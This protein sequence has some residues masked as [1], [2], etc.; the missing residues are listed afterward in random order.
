[1]FSSPT[2]RWAGGTAAVCLGLVAVTYVG[3]V[4]PRRGEAADLTASAAATQSR[5][6]ALEVQVAQLKA[7]FATLPEKQAE[8]AAVLGQLPVD[9]DVPT[10][11]RSLDEPRLERRRQPR[12]RHARQGAVPRR[13]RSRDD[14]RAAVGTGSGGAGARSWASR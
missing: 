11:V 10:F 6:D 7:Q 2:S 12:H 14:D 1:M 4:G 5:N 3:L 8:L 13:G 9:A